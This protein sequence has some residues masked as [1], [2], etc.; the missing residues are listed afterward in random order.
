MWYPYRMAKV[1]NAKRSSSR[2]LA[3]KL[4]K[5]WSAA[6]K[7]AAASLA[8]VELIALNPKVDVNRRAA[9]RNAVRAY[10]DKG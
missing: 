8:K 9:I 1:S 5:D 7:H 6:A 10:F 2:Q 4:P 3:D